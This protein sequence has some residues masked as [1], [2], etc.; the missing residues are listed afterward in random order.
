ML[1]RLLGLVSAAEDGA[2]TPP[3]G[4]AQAVR[5]RCAGGAVALIHERSIQQWS[6][7]RST[8]IARHHQVHGSAEISAR[9]DGCPQTAARAG[10]SARWPNVRTAARV[11]APVRRPNIHNTQACGGGELVRY[12][13]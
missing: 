8:A 7:G 6:H 5:M 4:G 2:S 9:A 13:K 10:L 12:T 1:A 3:A 11:T